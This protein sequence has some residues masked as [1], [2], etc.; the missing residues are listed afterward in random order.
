MRRVLISLLLSAVLAGAAAAQ[1]SPR[2][3]THP[4][5]TPP[6]PSRAGASPRVR[7]PILGEVSIGERA[8]DFQLDASEGGSLKL[9]RLRGG[10]VM[11]VFADRLKMVA[12]LDSVDADARKL[13]ARIVGVVHEKQQT[14]LAARTHDR[15]G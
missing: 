13:G 8:P 3:G 9:S 4:P 14:L 1:V 7:Q 5:P 12:P 10:W 6:T 11:L 2:D 15:S